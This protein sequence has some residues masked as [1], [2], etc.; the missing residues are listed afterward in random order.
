MLLRACALGVCDFARL[1][2][3]ASPMSAAHRPGDGSGYYTGGEAASRQEGE[4]TAG[5]G[6][7]YYPQEPGRS[8]AGGGEMGRA[9]SAQDIQIELEHVRNI[10]QSN[11]YSGYDQSG[12]S[13][14]GRPRPP[15]PPNYTVGGQ[16]IEPYTN[17]S[18]GVPYT[19]SSMSQAYP[20]LHPANPYYPPTAQPA[21]PVDPYKPAMQ[22]SAP[23][24]APH[25]GYPQQGHNISPQRPPFPQYQT[26]QTMPQQS[27]REESW[28]VYGGPNHYQWHNAPPPPA[29]HNPNGSHYLTSGRA[30]WPGGDVQSAVYDGKD[31]PQAPNYNQQRPFTGYHPDVSQQGPVPEAKPSPVPSNPHYSAS[32]QMYNRKEAPSQE[33][34]PRAKE[35]NPGTYPGTHP[36][37]VKINQVLERV[38]ELEREVDEFVGR[39][40]DMSY[41]CLEEL[42]TKELLEIDSV[43]TDGQD[44]I[45]QARK[46]AVRKLQMILES[47]ERKGL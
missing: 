11:P 25:W 22:P 35:V 28:N 4:E 7:G 10:L 46:D 32:P 40:T 12:W 15:Y 2:P 30:P 6:H 5:W 8:W 24:A 29:P 45:R 26:P 1:L 37:I 23:H 31:T 13:S 17:G 33:P 36:S 9:A 27:P 18:Y 3:T 44:G 21:Y 47:L 16:G 38:V 20:C 14:A 34:D 19:Q 42:L 43:E 39:K 41:R